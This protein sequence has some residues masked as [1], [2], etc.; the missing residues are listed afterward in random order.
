MRLNTITSALCVLLI[1]ILSGCGGNRTTNSKKL[2]CVQVDKT[3]V[4]LSGPISMAMQDCVLTTVTPDIDT[5]IINS[6]GGDV[7]ASRAIGYRIGEHPRRIIVEKFCLSACG[8]YF[9]PAAQSVDLEYGAVIGLHGSPD[10]QLLSSIK[11]E[12]HLSA[13]QENESVSAQG[14]QRLLDREKKKREHHLKAEDI[15]AAKFNVPKGWRHYRH[16]NDTDD[17]WRKHF[18]VGTDAGV[19]PK[20]FMIV[21]EA[22]ITSCLPHLKV[23][24][25]QEK[26]AHGAFKKTA[27]RELQNKIG[28]Y[29]SLGLKC[30]PY[31]G[32]P[33]SE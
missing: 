31:A 22:M 32:R 24:S 21:E 6:I 7:E 9:I 20:E 33:D 16:A 2:S 25:F 8:N 15:F 19:I 10:P 26:L 4:K 23:N 11:L 30:R 12:A 17:G 27:W 3:T 28:A 5:L 14:A 29:R 18:E 1:S 13:L